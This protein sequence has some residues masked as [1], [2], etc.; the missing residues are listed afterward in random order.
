[1]SSLREASRL[2]T[3]RPGRSIAGMDSTPDLLSTPDDFARELRKIRA[4]M[5]KSTSEQAEAEMRASLASVKKTPFSDKDASS[6]NG[7]AAP[8]A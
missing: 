7:P 3:P 4:E 6:S 8:G 2:Q 1:M 5:P